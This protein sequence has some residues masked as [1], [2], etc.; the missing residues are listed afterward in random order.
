MVEE[1]SL[2]FRLTKIDETRDYLIDEIKH[3][4]L[5]IEKY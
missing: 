4:D 1:V 2:N 5:M 3:D